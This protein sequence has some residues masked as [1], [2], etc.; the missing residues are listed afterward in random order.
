MR[1]TIIKMKGIIQVLLEEGKR[2][3]L[4]TYREFDIYSAN[5]KKLNHSHKMEIT[6]FDHHDHGPCKLWQSG[7]SKTIVVFG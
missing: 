2:R 4:Q 7:I 1:N 3:A 5:T 6:S